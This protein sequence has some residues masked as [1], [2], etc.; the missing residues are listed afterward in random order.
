MC[1]LVM[2]NF[3][4]NTALVVEILWNEALVV[5]GRRVHCDGQFWERCEVGEHVV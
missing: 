3:G 1:V 4:V 5:G 2:V